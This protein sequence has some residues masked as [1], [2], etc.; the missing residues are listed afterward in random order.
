[1]KKGRIQRIDI[2]KLMAWGPTKVVEHFP[3]TKS[4]T[5][6]INLIISTIY[7]YYLLGYAEIV[8]EV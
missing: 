8:I 6:K 7:K 2:T 4:N 1:M 3:V 5:D